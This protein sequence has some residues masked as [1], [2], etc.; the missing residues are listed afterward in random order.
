MTEKPESSLEAHPHD[1]V[2]GYRATVASL[3]HRMAK[4]AEH[5]HQ[6]CTHLSR[7]AAAL[8]SISEAR[9]AARQALSA[10]GA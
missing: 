9:A 6:T 2:A 3:H 8:R 5:S 1:P 4:I 7:A 10:P